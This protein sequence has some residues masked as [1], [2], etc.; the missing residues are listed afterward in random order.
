MASAGERARSAAFLPHVTLFY[1]QLH[2]MV[3]PF[4]PHFTRFAAS[5]A[6]TRQIPRN[7]QARGKAGS[8]IRSATGPPQE[9]MAKVH[10]GR[11]DG[12][13]RGTIG[14]LYRNVASGL[15]R[16]RPSTAA[17]PRGGRQRPAERPGGR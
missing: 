14:P 5:E 12:T 2:P 4:S 1:P 9:I 7:P 6:K 8:V 3:T 13:D 16:R 17:P 11:R 10:A 15:P